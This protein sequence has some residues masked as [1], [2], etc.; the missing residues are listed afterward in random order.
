MPMNRVPS[1]L[2][3]VDE[4][5][6][7]GCGECVKRC[8]SHAVS[9]V[10]GR[11]H[12]SAGEQCTYCGVCEDVCPEGAVSLYFEVVIAPAARGQESMQTIT[13]EP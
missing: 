2:P 8:P 12:F 1:V 9:I 7:T 10:D 11:V 6:C 13:E 3:V 4:N 5:I